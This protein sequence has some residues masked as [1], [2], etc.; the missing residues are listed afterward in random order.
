MPSKTSAL[1]YIAVVA[2]ALLFFYPFWVL[3]L[4][5]FE[6]TKLTFGLIYPLQFPLEITLSN[7][8]NS[9]NQVDLL[10][11]L[12]R[13]LEVAFI[14]GGL[15]LLLGIPA[16]Y[17][18]AKLTARISNKIIAFLFIINMMPGLV[19]AIPIS[20]YFYSA[21]LENTVIG[22]A[23]AQEL[24]VLPLTV[25]I[26]MGG[27]RS[28]PRDLENQARVDGAPLSS[29]FARILL[30]LIRVPILIAFILSWMT[31]WDEFT[32]AF[33]VAPI[34]PTDSTFPVALYN[35]V[36]RDL[37][38]QSATFA[39]VATVP[40]IILVVVFQKYL[41]GQYLSGGLIG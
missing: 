19:I 18:I 13:S 36:T 34:V 33:I 11:P 35:Y 5:A 26:I 22:V 41:K 29:T 27:F 6:P 14:V 12:M 39:L 31:S 38:L 40:V 28:L 3:F 1:I 37:P 8:V 4:I 2:L 10:G 17:G 30:P 15:A 25:F 20:L 32:Y 21:H 23:L 16:G 7:I 9:F 24:V